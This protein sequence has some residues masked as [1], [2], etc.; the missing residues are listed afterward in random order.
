MEHGH[1]GHRRRA[2]IARRCTFGCVVA[3]VVLAGTAGVGSAADDPAPV[4]AAPTV[5]SLVPNNG[6]DTGGTTVTVT[7]TG[8]TGATAVR[9]GPTP[10]ASFTVVDDTTITA[11]SPARPVGIANVWVQTPEGTN[12]S[13]QPSWFAFQ[14]APTEPPTVTLVTP[15]VGPVDGGTSVTLTGTNFLNASQVRFGPTTAPS[16]LV[17]S[18]TSM[19]VTTP[20]RPVG[21]VNVSV[22]NPLGTNGN[23]PSSWYS[24]RVLTGPAPTVTNVTPRQGPLTGGTNVTITGTDLADV[25]QVRFGAIPATSFTVVNDTTITAVS[26]PRGNGVLL[27]VTVTSQNGTSPNG[28]AAW[29]IYRVM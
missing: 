10:A 4:A 17:L 22:T 15:N 29:F 8:F 23:Q 14:S 16:F 1:T 11:V 9:F 18:N 6:L 2:R 24:Y 12:T 5:T 28:Q 19:I 26:P 21:L 25:Q 3:M 7:G 27:N 20:P 13:A